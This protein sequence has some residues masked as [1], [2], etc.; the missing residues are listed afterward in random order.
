MFEKERLRI[1]DL[2][3]NVHNLR[4]A[5]GYEQYEEMASFFMGR[6]TSHRSKEIIKINKKLDMLFDYLGIEIQTDCSERLPK[7]IKIPSTKRGKK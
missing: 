2:E 7:I 5:I 3:R 6:I 4:S 1:Q